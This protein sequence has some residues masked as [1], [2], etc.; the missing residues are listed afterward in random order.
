MNNLAGVFIILLGGVVISIVL[1]IIEIRCRKLVVL[2]TN[3]QCRKGKEEADDGEDI[4][5]E[6]IR[7]V[8]PGVKVPNMINLH[9]HYD[10]YAFAPESKL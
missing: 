6:N 1:V 7:F 2:L 8:E 9:P 4:P 3:G 5:M 10:K